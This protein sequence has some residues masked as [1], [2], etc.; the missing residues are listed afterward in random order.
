MLYRMM[1]VAMALSICLMA[2]DRCAAAGA[3][4]IGQPSN[5]AKD[6]VAI[7]TAVKQSSVERAK[8]RAME[9]CKSLLHASATSRSL[10]KIVATF[11]NQCVAQALDPADG[12][13]GFG[14]AIARN[15]RQA[16]EQAISNCR[17]TAGPTRQDACVVNDQ[18][19]WCDG[20][21]K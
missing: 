14:W 5:I 9:G 8:K 11:E 10:C 19:L 4:A 16:K 7:F 3:V 1:I 6:G 12:T 20:S 18:G 17:D 13:P 2:N 21:A 15:S